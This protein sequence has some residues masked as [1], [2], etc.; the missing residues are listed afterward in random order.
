[1]KLRILSAEKVLFEGEAHS[2]VVPG[3]KGAF[4]VLE[5]HAPIIST[6]GAGKLRYSGDTDAELEIASGF[7]D[8][9]DGEVAVGV[10]LASE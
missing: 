4:E 8:V 10:E 7:I 3:S 1:M 9:H 2:V 6:L 5:G